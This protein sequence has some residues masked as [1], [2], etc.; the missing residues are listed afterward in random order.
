M[1]EIMSSDLTEEEQ[2]EAV[3]ILAEQVKKA[4]DESGGTERGRA[5]VLAEFMRTYG[6]DQLREWMEELGAEGGG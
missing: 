6:E 3:V 4:M 2:G 5:K 1:D